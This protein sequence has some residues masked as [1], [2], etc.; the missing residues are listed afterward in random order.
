ML[1]APPSL[2][3]L[4]L[5]A[6]PKSLEPRRWNMSDAKL[7]AHDELTHDDWAALSEA[8]LQFEALWQQASSPSIRPF[9]RSEGDPL[10]LRLLIE[11]ARVDQERRWERGDRKQVEDYLKDWP[12]LGGT[13]RALAELLQSECLTRFC[14]DDPPGAAEVSRRFPQLADQVDLEQLRVQAANENRPGSTEQNEATATFRPARRPDSA[15]APRGGASLGPT[16]LRSGPRI[17]HMTG[18]R[19]G[20][21]EIRRL[22]ATGGMG[23]VYEA[24]DTELNRIVALKIPRADMLHDRTAMQRF[25]NEARAAAAIRHPHVCPI[26]DVGE[27]EGQQFLTM[28]LVEGVSLSAWL[29]N[30]TAAP[31][32]AVEIIRKLASAVQA[33]HDAGIRHRDIKASNVM[34]DQRGEPILMDFGLARVP[35]TGEQLTHSGS[36]IGTPAYMAPEQIHDGATGGD[37]RSDVYSLGVLLFQ[38]LTGRLPFEGPITRVLVEIATREPPSVQSLRPD[39]DPTLAALCHK[40]MS[41]NPTDRFQTARDFEV[42]VGQAFQPAP[43]AHQPPLSPSTPPAPNAHKLS[44][45][46]SNPDVPSK[47]DQTM[48]AEGPPDAKPALGVGGRSGQAGKP[49][50]R[51]IAAAAFV[52]LAGIVIRVATDNAELV[53]VAPEKGVEVS[54]R[55]VAG[56]D[57]ALSLTTGENTVRVRSGEVEVVLTGA[58]ADQYEVG[59]NRIVLKR[60]DRKV[61]EITRR[62]V[63]QPFQ[64][65]PSAPAK[66]ATAKVGL[67][68]PTYG[69]DK[70]DPKH[71]APSERVD[72]QP[73]GLVAVLGEHQNR[74]WS[75]IRYAAVSFD[76]S[77]F[78]MSIHDGAYYWN[79]S[80]LTRPKFVHDENWGDAGSTFVAFL[81]DG[82]TAFHRTTAEGRFEIGIAPKGDG[83]IAWTSLYEYASP[84]RLWYDLVRGASASIDGRWLSHVSHE[85]GVDLWDVSKPEPRR[86]AKYDTPQLHFPIPDRSFSPDSRWFCYVNA[87][88]LTVRIVDLQS[89]PPSEVAKLQAPSDAQEGEPAK[90]MVAATFIS[91]GRLATCDGNGRVWLWNVS[92]EPTRSGLSFVAHDPSVRGLIAATQAP[93]LIAKDN[94]SGGFRVWD[95]SAAEPRLRCAWNSSSTGMASDGLVTTAVAVS[96]D[97]RTLLTGHHTNALRFWDI[98]GA[99]SVERLP[100]TPNPTVI[101]SGSHG[102]H[103]YGPFVLDDLLLTT[104]ETHHPRLWQ[105]EGDRLVSRPAPADGD[106]VVGTL[107]GH[108]ADGRFLAAKAEWHRPFHLAIFRRDGSRFEVVHDIDKEDCHSAALNH[109]GSKMAIG[110][111]SKLELWDFEGN[112]SRKLAETTTIEDRFLQIEFLGDDRLIT[113]SRS[114]VRPTVIPQLWDI[115]PPTIKLQSAV[116]EDTVFTVNQFALAPDG[117]TLATAKG[118]SAVKCWDLR[119]SPPQVTPAFA[120]RTEHYNG[121]GAIAF[122]PDGSTLAAYALREPRDANKRSDVKADPATLGY[123]IDLIEVATGQTKRRL[124]YP[125]PVRNIQFTPDG[126]HLVTANGNSTIYVVRLP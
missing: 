9:L 100:L 69:W 44:A 87:S 47:Q 21:Y 57:K 84:E 58:N 122:S 6:S 8:V 54:V 60:N 120:N 17:G 49:D 75:A 106:K 38:L 36:L 20:R 76:G 53:I 62:P 5:I 95:L 81:G 68:R 102:N 85:R 73:E 97:G 13:P 32:E 3:C 41:R 37:E 56:G 50:L 18:Q 25:F 65:D 1:L 101:T 59:D 80:D 14:L 82:R 35:Q 78:A 19:F 123:G 27:V 67:E 91:D 118:E 96:P 99:Q 111:G 42:A 103:S 119:T 117:Q 26:F 115:Q 105:I 39:V 30:R 52:V 72:R 23:V 4:A 10:R 7:I 125:G 55:Q 11:L 22:I 92:K 89:S 51:W 74:A 113:R 33:V 34:I 110:I 2:C 24:R 66:S 109:D 63:G 88:D 15:D 116:V 61:V 93:V 86:V 40:A 16:R 83:A 112:R 46:Q 126:Q 64:A 28:P 77:Q 90:G 121:A 114:N 104:D 45:S 71:I 12:E 70:L 108:S 79:R 94:S 98:T 43:I 107:L 29:E 31:R 48:T 124:T